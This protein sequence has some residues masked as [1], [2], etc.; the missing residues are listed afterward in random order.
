[1]TSGVV[2]FFPFFCCKIYRL[3]GIELI[4]LINLG[5]ENGH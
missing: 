4:T 1:M 5:M 2:E 3:F